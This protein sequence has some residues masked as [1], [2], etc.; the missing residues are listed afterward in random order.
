MV[1]SNTL[2]VD[3]ASKHI[4]KVTSGQ[5]SESDMPV[6][7]LKNTEFQVIDNNKGGGSCSVLSQ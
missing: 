1:L 2:K 4:G 3:P 6:E 7:R 5:L